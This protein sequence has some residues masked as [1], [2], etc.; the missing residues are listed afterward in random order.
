MAE[1][2]WPNGPDQ[3]GERKTGADSVFQ[4]ST[5]KHGMLIFVKKKSKRRADYLALDAAA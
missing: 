2:E 1:P 3:G 4:E 5:S